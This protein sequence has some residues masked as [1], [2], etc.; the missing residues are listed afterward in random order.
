M[1]KDK[2]LLPNISIV[3]E[4]NSV[5]TTYSTGIV[6]HLYISFADKFT[7]SSVKVMPKLNGTGTQSIRMQSTKCK[8]VLNVICRTSILVYIKIPFQDHKSIT[9]HGKSHKQS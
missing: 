1:R 5:F 7:A 6:D 3:T 2:G 9:L 4:I 8:K